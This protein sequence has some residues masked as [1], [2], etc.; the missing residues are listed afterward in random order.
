ARSVPGVRGSTDWR[1]NVVR[2]I[3]ISARIAG[4][5]EHRGEIVAEAEGEAIVD[6][7]K[8]E[9]V[10]AVLTDPA[11]KKYAAD[12]GRRDLLTGGLAICG[13][14]GAALVA[15]PKQDGRKCY[16]CATGPGFAGCGKIRILADTFEEY[17]RDAVLDALETPELA[18]A[19]QAGESEGGDEAALF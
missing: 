4:L 2:R 8:G 15:R 7:E 9:R 6:R 1:P 5:R 18:R 12:L 17:V 11:R 13:E 19:L 14:C 16:V 10:R 3:L